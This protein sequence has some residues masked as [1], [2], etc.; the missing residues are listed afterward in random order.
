MRGQSWTK[1]HRNFNPYIIGIKLEN[2]PGWH[3][4]CL[5]TLGTSDF[6]NVIQVC[7][8]I[9]LKCIQKIIV[10]NGKITH[11]FFDFRK[12]CADLAFLHLSQVKPKTMPADGQ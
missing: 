8:K 6:I 4:T 2:I 7:P 9:S 12:F 5:I 1:L 3:V 11:K 10:G